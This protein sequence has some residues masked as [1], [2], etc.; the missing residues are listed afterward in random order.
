MHA[1]FSTTFE[2]LLLRFHQFCILNKPIS[3]KLS[4]RKSRK[5]IHLEAIDRLKGPS[6]YVSD[7]F[8]FSIFFYLSSLSSLFK[9]NRQ[10]GFVSLVVR[11]MWLV[12]CMTLVFQNFRREYITT[13]EFCFFVLRHSFDLCIFLANLGPC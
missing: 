9:S 10:T 5:K 12:S 4:R 11:C 7:F 6:A 1:S 8:V 3:S 2:G 13:L